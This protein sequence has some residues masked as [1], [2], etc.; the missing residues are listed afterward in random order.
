MWIPP[1]R[2]GLLVTC[3][4]VAWNECFQGLCAHPVQRKI[5]IIF[6]AQQNWQRVTKSQ[7]RVFCWRFIYS[8][9]LICYFLWSQTKMHFNLKIYILAEC[10]IVYIMYYFRFFETFKFKISKVWNS[11]SMEPEFQMAAQGA[12]LVLA[13]CR[14]PRSQ[15]DSMQLRFVQFCI[16]VCFR[17]CSYVITERI[18]KKKK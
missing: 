15:N 4:T 2:R 3:I 11:A 8:K 6:W 14:S 1:F 7:N 16:L 10:N 12:R 17:S 18:R 9:I 13:N 5:Y